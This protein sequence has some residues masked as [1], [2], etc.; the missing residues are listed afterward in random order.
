MLRK[1]GIEPGETGVFALGASALFLVGWADVSM[2]NVAEALFVKRVGVELMP[3]AFLA[4]SVLLVLTTWLVG[5][6][7][8]RHDRL[9]LLPRVFVGL[10]LSVVP[11]WVLVRL[12]LESGFGLL[13]IASKQIT[14]VALLV[15]WIAMG[16][17][18][19]SRQTKRLFAPMMAGVTLGTVLGSFASKP[20]GDWL[21]IAGLLPAAAVAMLLGGVVASRLAGQRPRIDPLQPVMPGLAPTTYDL[22]EPTETILSLWREHTLFR[23]LSV[24]TLC[25]GLLGPMLYFQFQYVAD[26]ATIGQGGEQKLLAFY[27]H[28]RG[29]IYGAVLLIQLVGSGRLFRRIGLPLAATFSPLTYLAGFLGLSVRLSLPAGVT[30]MAGTKIQDEAIYDPALRVLYSLFPDSVRARATA[31]L[32]GPVKRG[33]GGVGNAAIVAALA[34]GS[35]PWVGYIAIPI[36]LVWVLVSLLLWHRYPRLLLGAAAARSEREDALENELLDPATARALIP[37]ICGTDGGRA[38]LA[39]ELVGEADTNVAAR[40]LAEAAEKAPP[41]TRPWIVAALDRCLERALTEPLDCPD[42]ARQLSEL[43]RKGGAGLG[44]SERADLVRAYARLQPGAPALALLERTLGDSSAAARLAS[45]AALEHRGASQGAESDLDTALAGALQADDEAARRTARKE[46]S[47][48]LL[49]SAPDERWAER[50]EMLADAFADGIDRAETGAALADIAR[51]HRERVAPSSKKVLAARDDPDLRVR[52]ALL[53]WAGYAGQHDQLAWLIE[54]LACEDQECAAAAREGVSALGSISSPLLLRELSYGKRSKRD[55][56]IEVMRALDLR[57]EELRELYRIELDAAERDLGSLLA[58]HDR[59]ALGLLRQ[60]LSE[61]VHETL[62]TALLLLAAIRKEGRIAELGERLKEMTQLP[63]QR[64]IVVEALESFLPPSDRRGL[65]PLL[66]GIDSAE[67]GHDGGLPRAAGLEQ[68][69]RDLIEDPEELTR[70]IARGLLAAA[71]RPT[72]EHGAV[73]VVEIMAH[74]KKVSL[75]EDLTARQLMEL[76]QVAKEA[77]IPPDTEVV[78]QGQYDD[79]LYLVIEGVIHIRRADTLLTEIGPGEFFGEIALLEGVPRSADAVT[80]TRVRL[81][82]LERNELMKRIDE[83]PEIAVGMLRHLARR[84]REL[85][86][87]VIV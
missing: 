27:A 80:K 31:L 42:A 15:F 82:R 39:L 17:L 64:A 61:R 44:E 43:L 69:L 55:A 35:P 63:R 13:L 57:P 62:H 53:R 30:A 20:L 59:P 58:L 25:S 12:G 76:A 9:R 68:T 54:N 29:W 4:S 71:E 34:L 2:K 73:N 50:L 74:L 37:E 46:L 6:L 77:R 65:L 83:N 85:T 14:S 87:R 81:L 10:G 56:I 26:L 40:A 36:A 47:T 84:I 45:R 66:E 16:D 75:F 21:G 23:I 38:R 79:H 52:A 70:T 22:N 32:E 49:S 7:A 3:L 86:D 8:A 24:T 67:A 5:G 72:E 11:L 1:L 41:A 28:F 51:R 18:L 78:R 33:G 60:R 19:H 48:L